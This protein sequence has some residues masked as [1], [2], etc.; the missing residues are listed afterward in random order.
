MLS[1]LYR[2]VKTF[3]SDLLTDLGSV[4]R[5]NSFGTVIQFVAHDSFLNLWHRTQNTAKMMM[6]TPSNESAVAA[7]T[8]LSTSIAS[9]CLFHHCI[10]KWDDCRAMQEAFTARMVEEGENK[11]HGWA[12]GEHSV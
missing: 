11:L 2:K 7:V 4:T 8:P 10:C 1:R 9:K 12:A 6:I 5:L 3:R